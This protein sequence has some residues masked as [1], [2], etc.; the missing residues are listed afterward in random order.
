MSILNVD[1]ISPIGSGSTITVTATETKTGDITI[2]TG[3]SIFSPAGNTLVLGTNNSERIRIKNDGKV[4]VGTNNPTAKLEIKGSDNPLVKIVQDTSGIARLNL[5]SATNDGY[6]YSGIGLGDGTNDAEL[7]W[8]TGGFDIN[9]G[10]AVRLRINSNGAWGAGTNF[11]S[12]GQVLTSQGSGSPVQWATPAEPFGG[13][14]DGL[15]FGGT[16]TTYTSGSTTY[17]VHSFTTNGFLRVT[18]AT[19]MDFLI[20]G[21]GGGSPNAQGS[22]GSSG[23]GG[24]GGMVEG[25][26]ITIPI[27]KHQITVGASGAPSNNQTIA[28]SG[29]DSSI[30]YGGTTVVAKGGGGGADYAS[31]GPDGGCGGGGAEPNRAGGASIQSSQN[32]GISGIQQF[33]NAGGQGREYHSSPTGS[34]GGGGAGGAGGVSTGNGGAGGAGR[35]NSI[36]GSSVTYATGGAGG[37]SGYHHGTA[38]TNGLGNGA[39][40]ASASHPNEGIGKYGGSGIVIVRYVFS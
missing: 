6:Q 28:G 10:N 33:G 35:A 17:K 5:E 22:W 20:V 24:A 18:A 23:G 30:A 8:T 32:S 1:Q 4:G 38:G 31:N 3:T 39:G 19:S 16:E 25:T 27:G 40:G 9:V 7:M 15:I 14:L 13:A 37:G 11:G 12:A 26:G 29:G 34:G 36:T 21:G 2:G